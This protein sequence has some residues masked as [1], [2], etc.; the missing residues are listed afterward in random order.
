MFKTILI[1]GSNQG[2][3]FELSKHFIKKNCN[4]ILCARNKKKLSEVEKKLSK[5]KKKNQR[6][7]S[8][9]LDISSE[10]E[11]NLFLKKVFKKFKK[12]DAL[13]NCAGIYGPKGQFEK[14]SWSKWKQVIEINL[15]GSIYLIKKILPYFK[16]Q[17]KG[18][19][20]Q[21]AGGGAASSFPFFTA[22]STSKVALVRF[23]E[24]IAIEEK[25]NN[26]SLNCVAPGAVNTRMLDEVLKAGPNKVGKIFY[27]KSI[28][29]KK[30][31]G[32][33]INKINELVEFLCNEKNHF[34]TGKLIS[35]Q[36]DNWKKFKF[37]KDKLINSDLGTLRRIAGRDRNMKFFDK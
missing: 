17:K 19:I 8:Y 28:L 10:K 35:A 26:I 21:F 5:L 25:K 24:N 23:I 7:T 1:T 11:I 12:I 37:Y 4:L 27:K 15:L 33:D 22:Y 13:I 16:K 6:I 3:G 20:I 18:K 34:I 9:K 31:G 32:T 30:N 14:L 29:Q 36:W 2:I